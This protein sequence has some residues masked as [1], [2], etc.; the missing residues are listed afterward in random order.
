MTIEII[1]KKWLKQK[2]HFRIVARNG[3]V[4]CTSENYNNLGDVLSAIDSIKY[5]IPNA[6]LKSKWLEY[7]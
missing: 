7:S 3:R 6:Q 5:E 1:K 4:L 2:F